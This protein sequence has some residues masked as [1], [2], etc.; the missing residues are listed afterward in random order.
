MRARVTVQFRVGA[1]CRATVSVRLG[2][3]L[4]LKLG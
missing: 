2:V 3:G 4:G 1:K